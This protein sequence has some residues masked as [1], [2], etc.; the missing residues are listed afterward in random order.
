MN[1]TILLTYKSRS[2]RG[3]LPARFRGSAILLLEVTFPCWSSFL[4]G[5]PDWNELG[6][7]IFLGIPDAD[8]VGLEGNPL[9]RDVAL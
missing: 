1:G 9:S 5:P 7:E 3:F 6:G 8:A 4:N 2:S